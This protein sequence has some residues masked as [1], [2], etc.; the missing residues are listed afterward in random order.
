M[1]KHLFRMRIM[2]S[3]VCASVWIHF[4]FDPIHLSLSLKYK[5]KN[6]SYRYIFLSL[7]FTLTL[8]IN[9]ELS[10]HLYSIQRRWQLEVFVCKHCEYEYEFKYEYVTMLPIDK[11]MEW[12]WADWHIFEKCAGSLK[13]P[14]AVALSAAHLKPI[15]THSHTYTHANPAIYRSRHTHIY[16]FKLF[17]PLFHLN[18]SP[19]GALKF[20]L[21]PHNYLNLE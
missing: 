4:A 8:C 15:Q 21:S 13:L 16:K 17:K 6:L 1:L 14:N 2:F 12:E 5:C 19:C 7:S 3:S 18:L 10:R 9:S 11:W 20:F